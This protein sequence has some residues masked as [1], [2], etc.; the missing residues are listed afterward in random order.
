MIEPKRHQ[1][2][3][4][5][6]PKPEP[7]L[8]SPPPTPRS[9]RRIFYSGS[10][11]NSVSSPGTSAKRFRRQ[12]SLACWMRSLEDE[13]K[14]HQMWRA[15]SIGSPPSSINRDCAVARIEMRS[16][17]LKVSSRPSPNVSPP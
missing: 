6:D 3:E 10:G 14:F 2:K 13:T 8:H 16:P 12:S 5:D 15:L 11:M 7:E 17:G 1:P 9:L 4:I